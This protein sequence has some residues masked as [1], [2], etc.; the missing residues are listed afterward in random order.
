MRPRL[1]SLCVLFQ[2]QVAHHNCFRLAPLTVPPDFRGSVKHV[3]CV[4]AAD[5]DDVV[6]GGG[7]EYAE[8][9]NEQVK[10]QSQSD[11]SRPDN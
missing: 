4:F 7:V 8:R 1:L 10:F 11:E 6:G 3:D 9:T 5:D 2:H